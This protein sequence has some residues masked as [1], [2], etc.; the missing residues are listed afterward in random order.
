[1]RSTFLTF[2]TALTAIVITAK[3][4]QLPLYNQE[5]HR[6][7]ADPSFPQTGSLDPVHVHHSASDIG[8]GNKGGA[9]LADTLTLEKRAGL[10]WDYARDISA[11][12]RSGPWR[13]SVAD[14]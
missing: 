12:V 7:K 1:M 6:V 9:N 8:I 2:A 11:I 5:Q 10:W 3:S 13:K 4:T 14:L